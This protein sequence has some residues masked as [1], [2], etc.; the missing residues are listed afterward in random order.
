LLLISQP[1]HAWVSGQLARHWGNDGFPTPSE[2]VCL[3]AEQHDNGFLQWERSPTL[4]PETGLPYSFLEMP[5][6][7]HLGLWSQGIAQ[8]LR[9]GRYPALLVSMHF[10]PL[11]LKMMQERTGKDIEA[12]RVWLDEQ[13]TFQ[14]TLVTS[15]ANDFFYGSRVAEERIGPDRDLVSLLDWMSLQLC[16]NFREERLLQQMPAGSRPG[17]ITITASSSEEHTARVEPWPFRT[18]T[19]EVVCEGRRLL[20]QFKDEELMR[21]AVRGAAPVTL[22]MK[23]VTG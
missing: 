4:N 7:D 5:T 10:T 6:K 11:A 17:A 3:A 1:A 19:V 20:T 18:P 12:L 22:T 13:E 15:L 8:M 14:H 21:E 23:L 16:L 9:Y 2:E